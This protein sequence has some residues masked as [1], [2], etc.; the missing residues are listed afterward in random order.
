MA[1][2][3]ALI[4]MFGTVVTLSIGRVLV[5]VAAGISNV[6]FGKF[7]GEN[8][9]ERYAERAS[10][11][12]NAS[13]CVGLFFC[14]L[15]GELLP[16]PDDIQANKD[17]EL[18]RVIYLVPGIVGVIVVLLVL[19]VFRQ[20]PITYCIMSGRD[21]EGKRHMARVYRKKN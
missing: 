4:S 10:M 20:E 9:P 21:E 5:G 2:V 18:W 17:D 1:I 3:G 14:Y 8:M 15:M 12:L 13:V 19:L 11:M 7:I 16:S 6:T